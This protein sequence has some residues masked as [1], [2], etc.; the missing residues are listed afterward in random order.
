MKWDLTYLFK[1]EED[2]EKAFE[3]LKPY[4]EKIAGFNGKLNEEEKFVEYFY[5]KNIPTNYE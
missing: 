2:Y 3:E 4:L 1:T 5:F